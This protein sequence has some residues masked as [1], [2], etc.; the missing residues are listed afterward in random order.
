MDAASPRNLQV[1]MAE[2][3]GAFAQAFQY[4][5]IEFAALDE[6]DRRVEPVGGKA[7]AGAD[8]KC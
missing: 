1:A 2:G 7:S 8:A 4:Q 5:D 6:I 3:H